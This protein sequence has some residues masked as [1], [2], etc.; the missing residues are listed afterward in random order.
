MGAFDYF[1][2]CITKKYSDFDGRAT[3]SEY[4]YFILFY[5][6]LFIPLYALMFAT[7]LSASKVLFFILI[8]IIIIF[9]L[10]MFIPN[11]AVT[12]R[13]LHDVGKSGWSILLGIIPL[14]GPILLLV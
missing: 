4:W 9:A 7:A 13:R 1:K 8:S 6:L 10:G 12:V 14:V 11:L 5:F 2:T 3:R